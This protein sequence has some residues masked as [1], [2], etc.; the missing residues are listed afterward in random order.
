MYYLYILFNLNDCSSK[1][2]YIGVTN[3]LNRRIKEHQSGKSRWTKGFGPWKLI[4]YEGFLSRKDAN[5]REIR[6]KKHGKC[7]S[8]LKKRLKYSIN[9]A[10]KVRDE[11]PPNKQILF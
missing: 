5:Q 3:S 2:F 1:K 8:E 7:F 9:K 10:K 6:L 4:Y 11:N